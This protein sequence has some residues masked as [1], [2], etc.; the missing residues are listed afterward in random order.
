MVKNCKEKNL[1]NGFF[2]P[3]LK[4][5]W[6]NPYLNSCI[7]FVAPVKKLSFNPS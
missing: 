3:Y 4:K 2:A 6:D 1:A 7:N 5:T